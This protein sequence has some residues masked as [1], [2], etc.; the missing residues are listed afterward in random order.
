MRLWRSAIALSLMLSIGFLLL[1]CTQSQSTDFELVSEKLMGCTMSA[2][3]PVE[4]TS[5]TPTVSTF[6]RTDD[7]WSLPLF[8]RHAESPSWSE[9]SQS[10]PDSVDVLQEDYSTVV[11]FREIRKHETAELERLVTLIRRA[12]YE[13]VLIGELG[14]YWASIVNSCERGEVGVGG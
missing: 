14:S 8:F 13:L 2:P 11:Q 12:P 10:A 7:T 4:M 9:S 5:S 1:A 3:W 6:V